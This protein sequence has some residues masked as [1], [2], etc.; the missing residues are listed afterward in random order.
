MS[1]YRFFGKAV[2][3]GAAVSN[4]CKSTHSEGFWADVVGGFGFGR[5]RGQR[6]QRSSIDPSVA[7]FVTNSLSMYLCIK[8]GP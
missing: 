4:R 2:V 8:Q 3:F 6:G 1:S 5:G 7:S